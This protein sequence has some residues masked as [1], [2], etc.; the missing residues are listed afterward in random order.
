M[1]QSIVLGTVSSQGPPGTSGIYS[2]G[3]ISGLANTSP[4]IAMAIASGVGS[5][6]GSVA[7][8][9]AR[10]E[11]IDLS[12]VLLTGLDAAIDKYGTMAA[13]EYKANKVAEII[14]SDKPLSWW[15]KERVRDF[16]RDMR[17]N[18]LKVDTKS[19][20][21]SDGRI[22]SNHIKFNT[23]NRTVE[24][25]NIKATYSIPRKYN[26]TIN[27][28]KV[29]AISGNF[30]GS[31]ALPGQIVGG[32]LTGENLNNLRIEGIGKIKPDK[33]LAGTGGT[34]KSYNHIATYNED[35]KTLT[36]IQ[37]LA[38]SHGG[39]IKGVGA[40]DLIGIGSKWNG[41]EITKGSSA[42]YALITGDG[43]NDLRA[44][45][46]E[47]GKIT[48]AKEGQ[49][50][51]TNETVKGSAGGQITISR[52]YDAKGFVSGEIDYTRAKKGDVYN[53]S[54]I[55]YSS[56]RDVFGNNSFTYDSDGKFVSKDNKITIDFKNNT[57]TA[58]EGI[59]SNKVTDRLGYI[60]TTNI[61]IQEGS[62]TFD[63]S[64]GNLSSNTGTS[65]IV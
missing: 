23:E 46:Y 2:G 19:L 18:G 15:E 25:T 5:V 7:S 53:G 52:S 64:S 33:S 32:T 58:K 13:N 30:T 43:K 11:K 28:E 26:A 10:G 59:Y 22:N 54:D 56:L 57:L 12:K 49:Y 20:F 3:L 41:V 6:A 55:I 47:N 42:N 63:L 44:V 16:V 51:V 31:V 21:T 9:A 39:D 36:D 61:D 8:S 48:D 1:A 17:H 38:I 35:T 24:L 4:K 29:T 14:A 27:G 65:V 34:G 37:Q 40:G 60:H 62:A 50:I 45:N